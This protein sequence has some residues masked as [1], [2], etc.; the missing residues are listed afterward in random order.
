MAAIVAVTHRLRTISCTNLELLEAAM[1]SQGLHA[2]L[3]L[4]DV[5]KI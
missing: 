5:S 2:G 3:L 4:R 1:L